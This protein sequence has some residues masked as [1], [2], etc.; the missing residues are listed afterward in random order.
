[1]RF[2]PM[3]LLRVIIVTVLLCGMTHAAEATPRA[4]DKP[5]SLG[6]EAHIVDTM[7]IDSRLADLVRQRED[8]ARFMEMPWY[9]QLF[10]N[11]FRI[12]DPRIRYPRFARFCVDVYNWGDRTFNRYDT[13][14]VVGTGKNWK[15]MAKSYNWM[16]SYAL[17]FNSRSFLRIN[18]DVY[19]DLGAYICFMAVST[20]YTA[21]ANM[22]F[23][24]R[25]N[26]RQTYNFTFTCALFSATFNYAKTRGGAR[27]THFGDYGGRRF[28]YDFDGIAQRTY[29]GALYYFFN[30]RRYSQA[31]AYSFSKYQLKSAGSW[32]AGFNFTHQNIDMDF[33]TLP[34][35]M[36]SHL[37]SLLHHYSFHYTDY[38]L[39]GGYAHNWVLSPRKWLINLTALPSVGYKHSN[40]G[41][42]EGRKDMFSTNVR[43]MTSV[44]YNHRSLFASLQGNFEGHLY[45]TRGYTFFNSIESLSLIVG[46]RF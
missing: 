6:P 24:G 30:H 26:T 40:E 3:G 13:T 2:Q 36:L 5:D 4:D 38:D 21:N 1:M 42:T 17:Y 45:F 28:S 27:I 43:L 34:P 39:M 12:N 16:E 10:H 8:S 18:S 41:T 31:A 29:S 23:A 7:A 33:S 37:P 22:V 25:R 32:L 20:G 19:S 35:E 15:V 46:C 11:N 44:V 14:Y 9:K